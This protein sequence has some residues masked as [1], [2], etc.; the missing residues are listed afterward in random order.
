MREIIDR[1]VYDTDN[2]EQ[3]ANYGSI[4]DKGDFHTLAE[5]LYK[6]PNGEYFLHCQGG[7]ATQYAKQTS[8]GTTYGEELQRLTKEGALDWCEDRSINAD[9][10]IEEFADLLENPDNIQRN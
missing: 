8:E 2:A 4:V 7:A 6:D 1:K 3:I 9:S 10:I 5:A